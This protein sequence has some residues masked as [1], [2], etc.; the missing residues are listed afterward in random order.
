VVHSSSGYSAEQQGQRYF[1][2]ALKD[3]GIEIYEDAS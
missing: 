2:T 3:T 1:N